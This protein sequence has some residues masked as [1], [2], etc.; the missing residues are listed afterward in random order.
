MALHE[1]TWCMVA[2]CTQNFRRDGSSFV[3]HQP[4]QRCKYTTSVDIQNALLKA[5]HSCRITCER[6]E[7]AR[8]WRIALYKQSPINQSILPTSA[9][10]LANSWHNALDTLRCHCQ[11]TTAHGARPHDSTHYVIPICFTQSCLFACGDISV[12]LIC[13]SMIITERAS[14]VFSSLT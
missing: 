12:E 6:S 7:S 1:V 9:L 10:V 8:Q 3:W 14:C 11:R 2:W 13:F 4:C 5:I